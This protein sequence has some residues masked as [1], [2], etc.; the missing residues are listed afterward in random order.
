MG[1]LLFFINYT[2]RKRAAYYCIRNY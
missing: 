2:D 1:K